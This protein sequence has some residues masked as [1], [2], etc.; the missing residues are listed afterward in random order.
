MRKPVIWVVNPFTKTDAFCLFS[1]T[2]LIFYWTDY[3]TVYN[4]HSKVKPT[5]SIT[6]FTFSLN[7][8]WI[9]WR[10][11]WPRIYQQLEG[12][13]L[14]F[15]FLY[16]VAHVPSVVTKSPASTM[17]SSRAS[18]ARD[19]SSEQ[20]RTRR[21]MCACGAPPAQLPQA[22]ARSAL[23]AGSTSV[24]AWAWNWKVSSLYSYVHCTVL[25]LV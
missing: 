10:S 20:C 3:F 16:S 11:S 23:P 4:L 15:L 24:Y 12:S 9:I 8:C 5:S 22:H 6:Q 14:P 17:A 2:I 25:L 7:I 1:F 13:L 19:S 18:R 21:T